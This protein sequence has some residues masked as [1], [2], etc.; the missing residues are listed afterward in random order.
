LRV[1][2]AAVEKVNAL[3]AI[4][5][6]WRQSFGGLVGTNDV[7]ETDI[8]ALKLDIE[9]NRPRAL[10]AE[11]SCDLEFFMTRDVAACSL[12]RPSRFAG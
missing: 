7:L 2:L 6:N 3:G 9:A 4:Q 1:A 10:S 5:S 8:G 12:T 11:R